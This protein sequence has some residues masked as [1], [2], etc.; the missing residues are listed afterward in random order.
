MSFAR[1]LQ[2]GALELELGGEVRICAID[3][4]R[5]QILRQ[6]GHEMPLP[7]GDLGQRPAFLGGLELIRIGTAK[8]D[9]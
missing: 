7:F 1:L 9:K 5:L 3:L 4:R 2:R 8:S 6:F